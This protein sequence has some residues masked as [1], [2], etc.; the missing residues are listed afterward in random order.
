[1]RV[2][3]TV[4][5]TIKRYNMLKD[6][7]TVVIGVSGGADS[8]CLLNVMNSL[9]KK[10]LFKIVACHV[11]HSIRLTGTA[12]R[13]ADFVKE[14][15]ARLGIEYRLKKVDIPKIA[16]EN[17][18]T[19][20][21]AGRVERYK[22]FNEIGKEVSHNNYKIATGA[23]ANDAVETL[24]MRV[25]RGTT[26]SGLASIPYVNGNIIRPLLDVTRAE[27]EEYL[28]E[29]GLTHITDETNNETVFTRNKVRLE[30]L[31]WIEKNM[32]PNV[33]QTVTRNIKNCK[34]DAEFIDLEV[35]KLYLNAVN[36]D[37]K[38]FKLNKE[39]LSKAHRS[40]SKRLLLRVIKQVIKSES[41]GF[42]G[43]ILDD[44][45]D[46]IHLSGKTFTV[47]KNCNVYVG[48]E[49]VMVYNPNNENSNTEEQASIKLVID[50]AINV[51][52]DIDKKWHIK[53]YDD[54]SDEFVNTSDEMYIPEE[55]VLDKTLEIR[56]PKSDDRFEV[57]YGE[58][59]KKLN[60]VMAECKIEAPDRK[61]Q[62]VLAMGN[63][64]LAII[65]V[66]SSRFKIRHGFCLKVEWRVLNKNSKQ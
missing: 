1:M 29:N 9:S 23:N 20:E 38:T 47:D 26:I 60:K 33:M 52:L 12:E 16:K 8:I 66:K 3:D 61:N 25:I 4:E 64:V 50:K 19:E 56:Y 13:D 7:D 32:N 42:N 6:T 10:Y 65:G 17:G 53:L 14:E 44:I 54:L 57:V 35:D 18:L 49:L 27:I 48:N 15:C 59:S 43:V 40:I 36:I 34:E 55:L 31:P 45:M 28:T 37:D 30:L 24:F 11:N 63:K 46:S 62:L 21:E 51:D 58:M 22:F 39:Q 2:V 41:I 5:S